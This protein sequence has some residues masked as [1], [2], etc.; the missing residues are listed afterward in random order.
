MSIADPVIL[1]L[2]VTV[3]NIG[4]LIVGLVNVLS[5]NVCVSSRVT[6]VESIVTVR[7]FPDPLVSI[8]V[9]PAIVQ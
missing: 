5:V 9:P 8:P 7:V 3:S 1:V 4:E 2:I 6:T